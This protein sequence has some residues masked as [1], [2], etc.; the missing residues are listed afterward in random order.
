M[1]DFA[2]WERL[3]GEKGYSVALPAIVADRTNS[4]EFG[5]LRVQD[6]RDVVMAVEQ[7]ATVDRQERYVKTEG[8]YRDR[9]EVVR[10]LTAQLAETFAPGKPGGRHE[11]ASSPPAQGP[12]G[13]QGRRAP[14]WSRWWSC[15]G[16]RRQ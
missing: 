7:I 4:Q 9:H 5:R 13:S 15:S 1:I 12:L 6:F 16:H 3:S 8:E 14:A 10:E 11:G 2:A